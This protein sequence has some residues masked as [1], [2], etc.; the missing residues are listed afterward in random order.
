[1]YTHIIYIYINMIGCLFKIQKMRN[2]VFKQSSLL[3]K[4]LKATFFIKFCSKIDGY[5]PKEKTKK[6]VVI[7]TLAYNTRT[8]TYYC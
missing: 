2:I 5:K 3:S 4:L 1:M 8:K 7:T 6:K